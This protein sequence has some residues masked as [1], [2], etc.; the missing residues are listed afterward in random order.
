MN[1]IRKKNK[2]NARKCEVDGY[3]FDSM[4]EARRYGQLKML[5]LGKLISDL[6]VHPKYSI[7]VNGQHIC[8]YIA[9]FTYTDTQTGEKICED[10]KGKRLSVY[11]LKRKLMLACHGIEVREVRT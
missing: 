8:T 5:Q 11:V 7:D 3:V 4:M 9:D 10:V 6:K 2:F 1:A